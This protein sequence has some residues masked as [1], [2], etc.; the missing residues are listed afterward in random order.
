M[1]SALPIRLHWLNQPAAAAGVTWGVPWTKGELNRDGLSALYLGSPDGNSRLPLQSRPAAYWPDGTIKWSFHS[2]VC[3]EGSAE[4]YTLERYAEPEALQYTAKVSVRETEEAYIVDTGIIL[5]TVGKQGAGPISQIMRRMPEQAGSKH[6]NRG[7]SGDSKGVNAAEGLQDTAAG[8]RPLAYS[9]EEQEYLAGQLVCSGSGLVCLREQRDT[10]SGELTLR[11]ER[12]TGV[13]KQA[14]LEESG[15][16]RAVIRLDGRHRSRNG[17][18]EWLPYTLRL[19]FY[20]G[21]ESIRLVHTFHYDGNPQEDFIKGLG[22]EFKVPL[23]GPL[24]NRH[25]RF[26]GSEGL[27][28]ESPK[29]LHT[30]RTKGKYAELFAAQLEGRTLQF[31]PEEDAYFTGLLRDSA[32]WDSF[33][34]VQDSS[35]HFAVHKRTGPDCVWIKGAEGRR[36]GGLGYVG[37]EGGGL[38]VGLKDFGRSTLRGLS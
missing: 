13:T 12:F 35:E 18:G 34:L 15:P 25:I 36:A 33:R 16:L 22:I 3:P 8:S 19:Y 28:S 23:S 11:Q 5:C 6:V 27:F 4:G 14:V 31:D 38:A 26:A 10:L 20:A 32:V 30:R 29:T 21:L 37:S 17:A 24:Y 1:S 2:A 9:L 7:Y